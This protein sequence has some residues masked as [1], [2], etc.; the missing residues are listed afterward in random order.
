MFFI[1]IA[2]LALYEFATV[3]EF[4]KEREVF[5]KESASKNYTVCNYYISKLLLE[6]PLML[7]L[8]LFENALTFYIVGYR[9]DW[10]CF[11]KF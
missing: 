3:M 5:V 9:R 2:Q 4:I 11:F 6:L 1:I 7:L 10:T 8:P